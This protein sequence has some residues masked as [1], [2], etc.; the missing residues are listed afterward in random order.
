[1]NRH[2]FLILGMS[3]VL[4][5][6]CASAPSGPLPAEGAAEI[7]PLS[8]DDGHCRAGARERADDARANGYGLDIEE[9][10]YR[11]TYDGCAEWQ[12]RGKRK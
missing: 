5:H 6:G 9:S 2:G 4:L 11:E 10:V 7:Q 1:M 12:A 8:A 3:A